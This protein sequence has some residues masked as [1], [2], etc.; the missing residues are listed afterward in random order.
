VYCLPVDVMDI[1]FKDLVFM[2]LVFI[3]PF[4]V[5]VYELYVRK[6]GSEGVRETV[7]IVRNV[8]LMCVLA[9]VE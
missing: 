6:W 7:L 3:L 9:L 5:L 8:I 2:D 1:V 4:M